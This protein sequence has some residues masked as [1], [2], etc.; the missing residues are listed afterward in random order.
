MDA[1]PKPPVYLKISL[2]LELM[3]LLI[4][5]NRTYEKLNYIPCICCGR[6]MLL[7]LE[8]IQGRRYAKKLSETE[9]EKE[10]SYGFVDQQT[11]ICK[12]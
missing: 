3:D 10:I 2:E 12:L 7:V 9:E 4:I 8:R 5:V 1:S 6:G 11:G